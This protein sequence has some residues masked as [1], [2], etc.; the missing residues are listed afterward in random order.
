MP[1]AHDEVK[2]PCTELGRNVQQGGATKP[3]PLRQLPPT[4]QQAKGLTEGR[5]AYFRNVG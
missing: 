1:G 2:E 4:A 3:V 5:G